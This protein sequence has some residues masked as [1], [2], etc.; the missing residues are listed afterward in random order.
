MS[1][2]PQTVVLKALF[3]CLV[4]RVRSGMT[5]MEWARVTMS[6]S[7]AWAQASSGC[8]RFELGFSL[9]EIYW[10]IYKVEIVVVGVMC[11]S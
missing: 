4:V 5:S 10:G 6:P 1:A 7:Q 8:E 3:S 11:G 9:N 2:G